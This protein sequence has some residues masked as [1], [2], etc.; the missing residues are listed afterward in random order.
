M[1]R[2]LCMFWTGFTLGNTVIVAMSGPLPYVMILLVFTAVA[3]TML[4][5][6][7][8]PDQDRLE[9]I[10]KQLEALQAMLV[11]DSDDDDDDDDGIETGIME[12]GSSCQPF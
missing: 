4:V 1:N 5:F 12:K 8:P 10:S 9:M 3:L 7:T 11:D 2:L 6:S